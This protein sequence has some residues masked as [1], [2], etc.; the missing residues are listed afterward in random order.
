M[1]PSPKRAERTA[2]VLA[3]SGNM[4]KGAGKSLVRVFCQLPGNK[5]RGGGEVEIKKHSEHIVA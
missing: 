1:K 5:L 2:G 3:V 4:A